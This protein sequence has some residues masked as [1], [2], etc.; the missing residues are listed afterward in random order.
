M[1][2]ERQRALLS[3]YAE[4]RRVLPWREHP[5]PY[6]TWLSEIMLQQTRVETVLPY[7][8]RFL[9]RWP[10]VQDLAG[11]E[12]EEV[13]GQWSGL[14]YYSRA[15]RL[16][17]AA[18]VVAERGGFPDT[19]AGLR[20]LPGVGPYTAGAIASIAFAQDEV[21]VDGNVERVTC[22]WHAFEDDPRSPGG[23]RQVT[24]LARAD[25]PP[26]HAS[27]W[28]QAL[29]DLGAR[30]CTP[31]NPSCDA[32]PVTTW[33]DARARG[34]QHELPRLP[35]RRKPRPVRAVCGALVRDG[36]VLMT[37]RP[38]TGLLAGLLELPG[39]ELAGRQEEADAL[40]AAWR[41]RVGLAVR[42]TT[43]LGEVVHVFTHRRLTLGVW[44]LEAD[45]EPM[46]GRW[47]LD[48]RDEAL[49]TLARKTL[50]LV[51][52]LQALG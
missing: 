47:L 10:T 29:M 44:A 39:C 4:H 3:W 6:H 38:E 15:R 27:A 21:A 5:S 43:R 42:P 24:E 9:A 37:R 22:R 1:T 52:E 16:H 13:L 51:P 31:R 35:A 20:Q 2:P 25:L 18:R 11:A 50:A 8:E 17:A 46:D 49:S 34:L 48:T 45:G 33:C 28:N 7:F 36:A 41:E 26:G 19:V 14:G 40:V 23:K 30:I 12:L 32:C